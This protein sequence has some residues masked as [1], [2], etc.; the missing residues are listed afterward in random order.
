MSA[1]ESERRRLEEAIAA[2]E[3]L[4]GEVDDAVLDTV[5]A[6]LR[7]KLAA[8]G[9]VGQQRKLLTIL[10]MDVAGSTQIV[11]DMDPEENM[12][13]MDT[14]LRRL[15][16]PVF[17][18]G[19]SVTRYMGDGFKAVFGV[20]VAHENDPVQAVR[21]G[22]AILSEAE[23]YGTELERDWGIVG[24][25]VRV[26]IHTGLVILGGF[27]EAEDTIMGAAVNLAARIESAAPPGSVLISHDTYQ[28]VQG[29]FE[30]QPLEPITAKGF[31][32]PVPVYR[33]IRARP[34]SFYQPTRGVAGV[35]T[36]MV[37]REAQFD[38][39]VAL[40][41]RV[42]EER[43]AYLV[44]ITGEAG[45]GK[46]RLVY[47]FEKWV[48][49]QPESAWLFKSRAGQGTLRRPYAMLRGL[50]AS[51]FGMQE[52]DP[53]HVVYAKLLLGIRA[54]V[55]GD[56][57]L[58][59][60]AQYIGRLLG[61]PP[62]GKS[63]VAPLPDDP[64]QLRRRALRYL[65]EYFA[66]LAQQDPA[67]ILLE[68]I[69]WADSSSLDAIEQLLDQMP[70]L[71]VLVIAAA[72]PELFDRH[73]GWGQERPNGHKLPL[74]P[75]SR[76]DSLALLADILQKVERMPPGFQERIAANADGNPYFLEEF[77]KMLVDEG[78]IRI[79]PDS[80]VVLEERLDGMHVPQ[81]L[82]GVLQAR[83]DRLPVAER[84]VLQAASVVGR[85]FWDGLLAFIRSREAAQAG[86]AP[87]ADSLKSL[88]RREL[89]FRRDSSVFTH[90]NEFI[91]KHDM[92]R[93]VTYERVLLVTRRRYHT[94]AAEWIIAQAG[95][96]VQEFAGQ[97]AQHL[98]LS[99]KG[100]NA[101]R[102]LKLAG[103][104][105][106]RKSAYREAVDYFTRGLSYTPAGDLE[107]RFELLLGR[108]EALSLMG[109][110]EDQAADLT[111]LEEM[112]HLLDNPAYGAEVVL[113]RAVYAGDIGDFPAAV[114]L[115]RQAVELAGKLDDPDMEA[116]SR[117]L[118]GRALSK[119]GAYQ[120]A[121]DQ[122]E[123]ALVLAR[124]TGD[125][126]REGSIL[127]NLGP[128]ASSLGDYGKAREYYARGLDLARQAGDRY[129]EGSALNNLGNVA[130]SSGDY[131]AAAEI[132][133]QAREI[134]HEIG[135]LQGEAI[136]AINLGVIAADLGDYPQA[137]AHHRQAWELAGSVGYRHLER[138]A[139]NNLGTVIHSQGDYERALS[140]FHQALDLAR[141]LGDRSG[142][143][144]VL[145]GLSNTHAALG[146]LAEAIDAGEKA[147]K[148]RT[149]L[150]QRVM[151]LE[152]RATLAR[153]ALANGQKEKALQEVNH[154]VA[155][156]EGG[157]SLAGAAD[158]VQIY[159]TCVEVLQA[160]GDGR[161]DRLLEEGG[162]FLKER[163]GM[164]TDPESRRSYLESVP[165]NARLAALYQSTQTP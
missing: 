77:I 43:R 152:S 91:F 93:E 84:N 66:G 118:F 79:G 125:L 16:G 12:A 165:W 63:A 96:R 20:P 47:E 57:H 110:R 119:S 99:G 82:V 60:K 6:A 34:R 160:A 95:D 116:R 161:A 83:L 42:R 164:I 31:D 21:A 38:T 139:L 18:L 1:A 68:D 97:I 157:G 32:R 72:R 65:G 39:L 9:P 106:A 76:P 51:R 36:R 100:E 35:T 140:F 28:H 73:P 136:T 137:E 89:I 128:V 159:L 122:L 7:E 111:A 126:R 129:L 11:R 130:W 14:A 48:D 26:G 149:E 108:E 37:G 92:L 5:I 138:V 86:D 46:S 27:S 13:I 114:R 143:S 61:Y 134:S 163:A 144:F 81:T 69:H 145:D 23:K 41:R 19:G 59:M 55:S 67:L 131:P 105:A 52:S 15:S 64:G 2:Q 117:Q 102:Y 88:Q 133:S 40:Y 85:I 120:P 29:L 127:N 135:D 54:A 151:A 142:E 49:S 33:V 107:K 132:Y 62:P 104:E 123:A 153:A 24:F 8:L 115:G 90:T 87:L 53:G 10:F 4:R 124:Q 147:L 113:R 3:R 25:R 162:R 94:L 155:F 56:E 98:E 75:L 58:N 44:T 22:L 150:A 74:A 71:P 158:P 148:L 78:A 50:L 112:V 154:V 101:L 121:M 80:W 70:D 17:D 30:M 45:V 103:K 146:N 109:G 141:T 156:L